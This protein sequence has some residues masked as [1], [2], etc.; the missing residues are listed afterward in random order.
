MLT[1]KTGRVDGLEVYLINLDRSPERLADI[2]TR[3]ARLGI[4]FTRVPAVDGRAMGPPPWEGFVYRRYRW[5]HGKVPNPG[6]LGCYLSHLAAMRRFI[7][8]GREHALILEDDAIFGDDFVSVL[9]TAVAN[10]DAWDILTLYG[11]RLGAPMTTRHLDNGKRIVGF[12]LNQTGTVGYLINRRGARACL[13][14]LMPM[15]LPIDHALT[16]SWETGARFRGLVPFPLS[17][18]TG[19]STIMSSRRFA[20]WRR[21][22]VFVFRGITI[23]ERVAHHLIR[24][25]IWLPPLSSAARRLRTAIW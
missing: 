19:P 25:P 21:A 2:A 9:K 10:A 22:G 18:K 8:S 4:L 1:E 6:E 13:D 15:S 24:D 23:A 12:W 17:T 7:D 20:H 11:N 3:L 14:T 16:R 5:R